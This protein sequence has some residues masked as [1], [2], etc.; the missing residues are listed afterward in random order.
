MLRRKSESKCCEVRVST[1]QLTTTLRLLSVGEREHPG[2]FAAATGDCPAAA[3]GRTD[4]VTYR[5][6]LCIQ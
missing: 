6:G 1:S 3:N 4:R 2:A 5:A